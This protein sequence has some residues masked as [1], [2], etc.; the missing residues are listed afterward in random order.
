MNEQPL[1]EEWMKKIDSMFNIR[2]Q[3][4]L[5][6]LS[7]NKRSI[8]QELSDGHYSKILA[9][10]QRIMKKTNDIVTWDMN[11]IR[12]MGYVMKK[13]SLKVK[14][15][16]FSTRQV[17]ININNQMELYVEFFW[18]ELDLDSVLKSY[19]IN[20]YDPKLTYVK[21]I[22][23]DF[24]WKLDTVDTKCQKYIHKLYFFMKYLSYAERINTTLCQFNEFFNK[25]K[26]KKDE[27]YTESINEIKGSLEVLDDD[28]LAKVIT[29]H[30]VS[31]L[32]KIKPLSTFEIIQRRTVVETFDRASIG[33]DVDDDNKV[34]V[35]EPEDD[36]DLE[37]LEGDKN[38]EG[39][40][41]T[42]LFDTDFNV[43]NRRYDIATHLRRKPYY[44]LPKPP[45]YI[46]N[47][48]FEW[49]STCGGDHALDKHVFDNGRVLPKLMMAY[50][51][52]FENI[53]HWMLQNNIP[54]E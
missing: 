47:I 45:G 11:R 5:A 33:N 20:I 13:K 9:L 34:K 43:S 3:R 36:E 53:Q 2:K 4:V 8:L 23:K 28:E 18:N 50:G 15:A 31:K 7:S 16:T 30:S 38:P 6:G 25:G 22:C 35:E 41:P 49:C 27:N 32:G 19:Q 24:Y 44:N 10:I 17:S 52:H 42:V 54:L 1:E 12:R 26:R 29:L 14:P 37:D 51:L 48:N 40:T 21:E 46:C 39:E